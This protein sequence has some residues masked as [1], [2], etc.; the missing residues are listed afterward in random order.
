MGVILLTC[1]PGGYGMGVVLLTCVP[2]GRR[3]GGVEAKLGQGGSQHLQVPAKGK[4]LASIRQ[5]TRVW[6]TS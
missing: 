3:R 1:S 5:A 6:A 4:Y 2:R